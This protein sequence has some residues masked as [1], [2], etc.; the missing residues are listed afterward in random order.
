MVPRPIRTEQCPR[1]SR[2]GKGAGEVEGPTHIRPG[3]G[4]DGGRLGECWFPGD[5]PEGM[6]V[7]IVGGDATS[8]RTEST[9]AWVRASLA[10]ARTRRATMPR[11]IV[12]SLALVW[13]GDEVEG[14]RLGGGAEPAV[15]LTHGPA[16]ND[17]GKQAISIVL[18]QTTREER[19]KVVGVPFFIDYAQSCL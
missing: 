7:S 10:L 5:P 3:D 8:E 2:L 1:R 19:K 12:R 9:S 4:G 11:R 18:K 16:L 17:P 6:N 13:L 14:E 15:D